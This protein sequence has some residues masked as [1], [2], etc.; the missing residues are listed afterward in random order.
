MPLK[1]RSPFFLEVKSYN[2][3]PFDDLYNYFIVSL[4]INL[5]T[6]L[7]ENDLLVVCEKNKKRTINQII[8]SKLALR[9]CFGPARV[10]SGPYTDQ[11][12]AI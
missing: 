1:I 10:I 8:V 11:L 9:N 2:D 7:I 4:Y 6:V 3:M 5:L 12:S